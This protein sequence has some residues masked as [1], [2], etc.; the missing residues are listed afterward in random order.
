MPNLI[1]IMM[2]PEKHGYTLCKKCHGYGSAFGE[3]GCKCSSCGGLGL[4]KRTT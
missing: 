4:I 3:A 2:D 1:D